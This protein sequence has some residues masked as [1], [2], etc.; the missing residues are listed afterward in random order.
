MLNG[1]KTTLELINGS[2]EKLSILIGSRPG[3]LYAG[4]TDREIF[5]KTEKKVQA[6]KAFVE[7]HNPDIIFTIGGMTSEAESL[8]AEVLVRDEGSP[9]VKQSPLY[10]NPDPSRLVQISLQDSPL[11]GTL[12]RSVRILSELYPDKI[13]SASVN[14]PLTVAGQLM[15]LEQLLIEGDEA[16]SRGGCIV[17]TPKGDVDGQIEE[18]LE[19]LRSALAEAI[20][21][22]EGSG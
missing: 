4:L 8:G 13:V 19:M 20:R 1:N 16:I 14:G 11:C 3:V 18:R 22:Q 2:S 6:V 5:E 10:E 15:G 12:I 17:E 9:L 21:T 7:K